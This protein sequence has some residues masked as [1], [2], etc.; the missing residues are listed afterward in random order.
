M[1]PPAG[2]IFPSSPQVLAEKATGKMKRMKDSQAE[3]SVLSECLRGT[4]HCAASDLQKGS[5][6]KPTTGVCHLSSNYLLS[7]STTERVTA[8]QAVL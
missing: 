4:R 1:L 6:E 8:P 5:N 7:P 2:K 3:S